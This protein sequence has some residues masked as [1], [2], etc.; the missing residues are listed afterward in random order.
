MAAVGQTGVEMTDPDAMRALARAGDVAGLA[1]AIAAGADVDDVEPYTGLTA[2]LSAAGAGRTDAVALLLEHGAD[3]N[4][5]DR[6]G[7]YPFDATRS[8]AIRRLLVAHGFNQRLASCTTGRGL[9]AM[10]I[11]AAGGPVDETHTLALE[12]TDLHLEYRIGDVPAPSGQVR[13]SGLGVIRDG[14]GRHRRPGRSATVDV[15]LEQFTGEVF[16][17]LYCEATIAGNAGP[18]EFWLP[19]LL[20]S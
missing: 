17:R 9:I 13:L 3:P 8:P 4:R 2:L 18:R 20:A 19:D 1:E 6:D 7:T 16:I 11:L 5:A 14:H 10:R 15:D 12:G